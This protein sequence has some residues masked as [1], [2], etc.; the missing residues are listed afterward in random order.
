MLSSWRHALRQTGSIHCRAQLAR[1]LKPIVGN[2][3]NGGANA[4][5]LSPIVVRA[6]QRGCAGVILKHI[7][8]NP[9]RA[10]ALPL[11]CEQVVGGGSQHDV[12][13]PGVGDVAVA[14][15]AVMLRLARVACKARWV[16]SCA[17]VASRGSC[18]PASRTPLAQMSRCA[19]ASHRKTHCV[20]RLPWDSR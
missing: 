10:I 13:A 1:G 16:G 11:G 8:Q 4:L 20:A 17:S 3:V 5:P 7:D 14:E 6:E 19:R 18:A 12:R 2:L 15:L 9:H